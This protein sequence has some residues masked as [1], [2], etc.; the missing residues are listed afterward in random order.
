MKTAGAKT[1]VA[2]GIPGGDRKQVGVRTA[3]FENLACLKDIFDGE[4][5]VQRGDKLHQMEGT[6]PG[7]AVLH[8]FAGD[9]QYLFAGMGIGVTES[10]AFGGGV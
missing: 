9:F 7:A 2:L 4:G 10:D 1:F 6:E 5:L 8:G 3:A